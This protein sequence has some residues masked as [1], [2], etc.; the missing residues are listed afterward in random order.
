MRQDLYTAVNDWVAA[1][2]K[3]KNFMGGEQP[4]LAD[5]VRQQGEGLSPKMGHDPPWGWAMVCDT[6]SA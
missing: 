6:Q 3:K 5:L 2:G 1:I 4:N